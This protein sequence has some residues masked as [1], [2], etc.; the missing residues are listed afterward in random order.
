MIE[1]LDWI[2]QNI[3]RY[4][5]IPLLGTTVILFTLQILKDI[6]NI[7]FREFIFSFGK[8]KKPQVKEEEKKVSPNSIIIHSEKERKIIREE[9]ENDD[10]FQELNKFKLGHMRS[11]DFGSKKKNEVLRELIYIY[12]NT[13]EEF[14]M[15]MLKEHDL[16]RLNT[17]ELVSLFSREINICNDVI[18]DTMRKN[19]GQKLYDLLVES[20]KGFKIKNNDCR[21]ILIDG[22]LSISAQS[23]DKYHND[24]YDKAKYILTSMTAVLKVSV[25]NFEKV[26]RDFNGELDELLKNR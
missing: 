17:S 7:N 16:D 3:P 1:F 9:L 23:P 19:L 11:M 2:W 10:F 15:R 4:I 6:F 14:A 12:M 22:I 24:N 25:R 5:S 26:F 8:R 13:I 21:E 18:Y 20:E